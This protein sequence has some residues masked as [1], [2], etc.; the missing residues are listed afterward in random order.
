MT[1]PMTVTA[2]SVTIF[3]DNIAVAYGNVAQ[4]AATPVEIKRSRPVVDFS[5]EALAAQARLSIDS[6]PQTSPTP[7]SHDRDFKRHVPY[8]SKRKKRSEDDQPPTVLNV[9]V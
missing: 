4:A 3:R 6:V 2:A 8:A 5:E 9:T 7:V 1:D